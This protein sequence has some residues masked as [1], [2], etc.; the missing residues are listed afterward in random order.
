MT[1]EPSLNNTKKSD[2]KVLKWRLSLAP[3]LLKDSKGIGSGPYMLL[4]IWLCLC[5]RWKMVLV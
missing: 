2:L 4:C 1:S 5:I 3:M